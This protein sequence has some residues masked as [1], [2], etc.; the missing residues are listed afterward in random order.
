MTATAAP[1]HRPPGPR[2]LQLCLKRLD[3]GQIR[4]STP[5]A[6]G[7]ATVARGPDQLWH[8]LQAAFAQA[9]L[10]GQAA[11]IGADYGHDQRTDADD[12][13]EPAPRRQ[14]ARSG[15]RSGIS[16]ARDA[17]ARPDVADPADWLPLPDGT[18]LSPAGKRYRAPR[19][20][21]PVIARRAA[22]GL[23]ITYQ[24][25]VEH[26]EQ[27]DEAGG[28]DSVEAMRFWARVQT[29]VGEQVSRWHTGDKRNPAR[30]AS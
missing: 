23:P 7:W 29:V 28:G 4:V 20:V 8:A 26:A 5:Q 6:R 1:H 13:T 2:H 14:P 15:P 22:L 19:I 30:V 10:A 12:P 3:S 9:G 24:A 25:A 18:W 11:W 21:N 27:L 16:W 17:A